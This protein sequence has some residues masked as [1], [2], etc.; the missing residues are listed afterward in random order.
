MPRPAARHALLALWASF[1]ASCGGLAPRQ[2]SPGL[3]GEPLA[4]HALRQDAEAPGLQ[5]ERHGQ[6]DEA[7]IARI[8]NPVRRGAMRLARGLVAE[9]RRRATRGFGDRG[10]DS[11]SLRECDHQRML[12][13]DERRAEA[14]ADHLGAVGPTM[15][16]APL[17]D[18]LRELPIARDAELAIEELCAEHTPFRAERLDPTSGPDRGRLAVRVRATDPASSLELGYR[19]QSFQALTS[20]D[21]FRVRLE[22]PLAERATARVAVAHHYAS[23][24]ADVRLELGWQLDVDT[25]IHVA[26]GNRLGP[27]P[28]PGYW[29]GA[30]P[31]DETG[32]GVAF[33][34]E[35][36]F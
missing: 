29:P 9:D 16:R 33:Y 35:R 22:V 3:P 31:A 34:V 23:A 8:E 14:R 32:T 20:A 13:E 10:L 18:A 24:R 4:P 5:L 12:R 15:L 30:D 25:R 27:L 1:L 19:Y 17:R 7:A 2:Q 6:L 26:M 21:R 28:A 36:L 11:W